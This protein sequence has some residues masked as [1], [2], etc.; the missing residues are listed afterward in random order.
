M[1]EIDVLTEGLSDKKAE[2]ADELPPLDPGP[3][4][5]AYARST[6]SGEQQLGAPLEIASSIIFGVT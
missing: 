1:S 6:R 3:V 5:N 2:P 4:V